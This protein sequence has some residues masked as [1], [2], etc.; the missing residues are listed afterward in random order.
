[1][2]GMCALP[3]MALG[4]TCYCVRLCARQPAAGVTQVARAVDS[5]A[6]TASRSSVQPIFVNPHEHVASRLGALPSAAHQ[7][8][9]AQGRGLAGNVIPYRPST[10][11]LEKATKSTWAFFHHPIPQREEPFIILA[12]TQ[13]KADARSLPHLV[14]VNCD[15]EESRLSESGKEA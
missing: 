11:R 13:V 8:F 7:Y 6:R 3:L 14:K 10:S 5:S 15:A 2:I 1:M 9:S 12:T 4:Y